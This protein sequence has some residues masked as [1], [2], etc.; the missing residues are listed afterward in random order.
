MLDN[1]SPAKI[2]NIIKKLIQLNLRNK[3]KIE[4][5]GGINLSNVVQYARSGVDMISIGRL[6]SSVVGLDLSLEVN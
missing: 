2:K 1:M 4:A 3:V 5:S 6:T